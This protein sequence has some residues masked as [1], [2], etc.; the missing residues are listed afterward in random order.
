MEIDGFIDKIDF[1]KQIDDWILAQHQAPPAL[2]AARR[3]G[4]RSRGGSKGEEGIPL[5]K[6]VVDDLL[7]ISK[8][9][10]V[11]FKER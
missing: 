9:A 2:T 7:D 3:P 8:R 10:G 11:A 1:K 6:P 4:A 5:I